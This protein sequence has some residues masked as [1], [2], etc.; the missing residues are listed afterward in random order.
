M[1]ACLTKSCDINAVFKGYKD[2]DDVIIVGAGP[3]GNSAALHLAQS[4]Y[5]VKVIETKDRIGDKLCTGIV[6]VECI[7]KY[8]PNKTHIIRKS[9]TATFISPSNIEVDLTKDSTQAY[10]LDRISYISS[11]ADQAQAAGAT[12]IKQTVTNVEVHPDFVEIQITDGH[13]ITTLT[14]K[15]VIISGGFRTKFTRLLGL[16]E[17]KDVATGIQVEM[18]TRDQER[19]QVYFGRHIAPDFF[20]WLVPTHPNRSLVGLLVRRNAGS[21]LRSFITKLQTENKVISMN[22]RPARWGV[23]LQPLPR[24]FRDRV[25]VVGDAAGQTKPTTGG[26][27]YYA[28]LAGEIAARALH[29]AFSLKD[30]SASQLSYYEKEWKALLE[31]DIGIGRGARS[32]FQNLKDNQIDS[33]MKT[34]AR[35]GIRSDILNNEDFSFD[36]HGGT[37]VRA[38]GHPLLSGALRYV[39]PLATRIAARIVTN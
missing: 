20:G 6:G 39:N 19:V 33:L 1:I 2:L 12:Y 8:P 16:G 26:G 31:R 15:A 34:I 11:I 23:A 21:Y 9:D 4:G 24:T 14:A 18:T 38:L 25:L 13:Q 35:N 22:G 37:I 30:L 3:A 7:E 36:W 17:V 10:I 32:L 29:K 28:F 5:I 27:I